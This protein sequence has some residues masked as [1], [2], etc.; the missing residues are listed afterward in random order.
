MH[1]LTA[2]LETQMDIPAM[3]FGEL[4]RHDLRVC[5]SISTQPE[6]QNL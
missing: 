6:P 1:T 4:A 5:K 3:Q 2:N